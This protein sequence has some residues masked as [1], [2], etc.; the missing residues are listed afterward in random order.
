VDRYRWLASLLI[1]TIAILGSLGL[2]RGA[3]ALAPPAAAS[4]VAAADP[5]EFEFE[6]DEPE[7]D[8]SELDAGSSEAGDDE[9]DAA[10][11]CE[12]DDEAAEEACEERL[13]EEEIE[14]AEAEECRLETAEATVAAIPG[15]N[16]L[17]L[18]VRYRAF[19]PSA[20]AVALE[21]R[22]A[23]GALELGTETARFGRSGT[24][25]SERTLSDSQMARAMAA[26]E[27]IVGLQAIDTP[28]FCSDAFERHLTARQHAGPALRWSDPSASRRAKAASA[29]R[30]QASR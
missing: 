8:E 7:G 18:T 20:V 3:E 5:F 16:Q 29:A 19:A 28:D 22:G 30:A 9:G 26:R 15:R 27:F 2:C 10:D 14:E 11:E 4:A 12:F 24:L 6:E 25:H 1:A 13:E 17:R 23:K 21:L